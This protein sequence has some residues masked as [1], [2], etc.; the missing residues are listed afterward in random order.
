MLMNEH[1]NVR[2]FV[3]ALVYSYENAVSMCLI[4]LA[5][6]INHLF[7][8]SWF[9]DNIN[10]TDAE[11]LLLMKDYVSGTFLVT[12]SDSHLGNYVLSVRDNDTVQHYTIGKVDN[13]DF[14]ISPQQ[15][16][17]TLNE[18][19]Q[20]HYSNADG[21]CAQLTVPCPKTMSDDWEIE[22]KSIE[23]KSKLGD[24]E[25]SEAWAGMW[26]STTPVTVLT[27][28]PGLVG[29][30]DFFVE[31]QIMKKLQHK[32][33][34][35]L[36]GV[37]TQEKPFYIV[38]EFM[39][40]GN[41]L[42]YLTKGKGRNLKLSGLIDI[43]AQVAEGMAYLESQH[44][45]HRD[46]GARNVLVGEG[47]I[48][49]IGNFGL[50][51]LLIYGIFITK[52]EEKYSIKWTDPN[53]IKDHQFT[54][55]S[56]VWSF[57][58]FLTELVT[59]GHEPYPGMIDD[60]M[61]ARV[62]QGYRMPPPPGCPD[63][64]YQMMLECWKTDPEERPTFEIL[65]CQL[66]DYFVSTIEGNAGELDECILETF[67]YTY[68]YTTKCTVTNILVHNKMCKFNNILSILSSTTA[69]TKKPTN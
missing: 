51:C 69:F 1:S 25:F 5:L 32:K 55:K 45:V 4:V 27:P 49:K 53:A 11:K 10:H 57:G 26:N 28:K 67:G 46:L 3:Y 24:R 19:I 23:L 56:D 20:H 8:C 34:I 12:K 44:C 9:S 60:E 42:D 66:D 14:Y 6:V 33:L 7:C 37:C 30:Y 40:H 61:L 22:Y 64:L 59:H 54:I 58:V 52:E 68:R 35:K 2:T 31:S 13:G 48:V 43:A 29:V 39:K 36:Y 50:A 38:T 63:P 15:Q 65:K 41:L 21:L 16:F 17:I 18:L 62:E 47:N